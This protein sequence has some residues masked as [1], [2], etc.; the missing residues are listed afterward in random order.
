MRRRG[1][2]GL[3]IDLELEGLSAVLAVLAAAFVAGLAIVGLV[4]VAGWLR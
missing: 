1:R 3:L 4:Q 2:K